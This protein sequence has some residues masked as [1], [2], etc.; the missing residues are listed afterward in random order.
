M[1]FLDALLGRN[2][3]V[4]PNLDAL[5]G[6]PAAAITLEAALGLRPTGTGA[7]AVKLTEGAAFE[8]ASREAAALLRFEPGAQ[9]EDTT[10]DYGFRWS[11]VTTSPDAVADLVTALHGANTTYAGSGLGNALLCTT[12]GFAGTV[13]GE[14]RRVAL[15]YLYKRGT[16][17]PFAPSGV[18]KRDSP[19][20]L[21]VRGALGSDLPVEPDLSRW[22]PVWG[23][24][25]L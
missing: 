5:F 6:I 21:E 9:V 7:V 8:A 24:P 15:V 18:Q 2:K 25:G 23:A 16:F 12:V 3:Q 17:Y 13:N 1:G 14:P 10:D 19:F 22:F 4:R 11:A 20:E